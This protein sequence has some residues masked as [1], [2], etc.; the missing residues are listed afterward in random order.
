MPSSSSRFL[1]FLSLQVCEPSLIGGPNIMAV[2]FKNYS[3]FQSPFGIPATPA[4]SVPPT[5]CSS[6]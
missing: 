3:S 5:C 4:L 1:L 6:Y 2:P